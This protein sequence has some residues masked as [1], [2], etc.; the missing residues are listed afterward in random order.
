MADTIPG[1]T[2]ST[3]VLAVDSYAS[4]AIDHVGDSDWWRVN[5]VAG[6]NY[7]FDLA[8]SSSGLGTLTDPFLWVLSGSG[9]VLSFSDD[10]GLGLF[11]SRV[12]FTPAVS[13]T[14]FLA[15]EESGHNATGTYTLFASTDHGNTFGSAATLPLSTAAT[16]SVQ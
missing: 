14:Y 5:L 12:V 2:S 13:G 9:G 7:V 1:N 4:S 8:G 16:G 6:R 3:A 11:D 15:A 10:F